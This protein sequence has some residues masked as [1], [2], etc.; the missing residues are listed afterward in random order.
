MFFLNPWVLVAGAA[1][2]IPIVLHLW[3][4]RPQ[5]ML[6]PAIQF[7]Q[8]RHQQA[9]RKLRLREVLLLL[10]RVL[11]LTALTLGFARPVVGPAAML[12]AESAS[13][14][15]VV[16]I[17]NS[18]R[19]DYSDGKQSRLDRAKQAAGR[20]ISQLPTGCSLA[21]IDC[22]PGPIGFEADRAGALSRLRQVRALPGAQP[23]A[24]A[25]LRACELLATGNS[26]GGEVVVIS[27]CTAP[28]WPKETVAAIRKQLQSHSGLRISVVDVGAEE[29]FN[30]RLGELQVVPE[31]ASPGDNVYVR[32]TLA[33]PMADSFAVELFVGPVHPDASAK[34]GRLTAAS[35]PA[36][37]SPRVERRGLQ[38]VTVAPDGEGQVQFGFAVHEEGFYQ[39]Y[40]ALAQ[41]DALLWDNRR[42][43]TVHVR[44]PER[45]LLVA[46]KQA[47]DRTVYLRL[48]LEPEELTKF[49]Q[50]RFRCEVLDQARLAE[51][52]LSAYAV[53]ALVDPQPLGTT[54]AQRLYQYVSQGG[55]LAIFLGA[56]AADPRAWEAEP[57]NSLLPARPLRQARVPE[58]TWL[59]P[60]SYH[61]P[62]LQPLEPYAGKL[63]W[64]LAPVFRYWQL[65]A[66]AGDA[67]TI[68]SFSD[69]QPAL[70]ERRLGAG[71]VL[72]L[73][74]PLSDPP[75]EG[76]WNLFTAGECWPL[77][78]VVHRM[79]VYLSQKEWLPVHFWSAPQLVV[80]LPREPTSTPRL[81]HQAGM[82]LDRSLLLEHKGAL[83]EIPG[84]ELVGNY[85]L[86]FGP[87]PTGDIFGFSVNI[88]ASQ[89]DLTHCGKELRE[90]LAAESFHLVRSVDELALTRRFQAG[91]VELSGYLL[92]AAALLF[93][94]ELVVANRFYAGA[95]Q[96]PAQPRSD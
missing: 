43:F 64:E 96:K 13:A 39:G 50:G 74:T 94:A 81:A 5:R 93:L 37:V 14:R 72:L 54:Q 91:G 22:Q 62:I 1:V 8:E 68:V 55:G 83:V 46:P 33:A 59:R 27:D 78:A 45:V 82:E 32:T 42:Y 57:V 4:R 19:M 89:T 66:P 7:I 26:G 47:L 2:A 85:L 58:G 87:E 70:V 56:E 61:H 80:R 65:S 75:R 48:M 3:R 38:T 60:E 79:F 30:I 77:L 20:L 67:S 44:P 15:V 12:T 31:V 84:G 17:D 25:T 41:A 53:I 29:S 36:A 49:G 76:S 95:E 18:V 6:F 21:V 51:G 73:A 28:G 9:R 86:Q 71:R 69:G 92:L 40:V 16:V 11:A 90:E 10:L 88:R 35:T 24:A 23:V 63:P 34:L 52:D